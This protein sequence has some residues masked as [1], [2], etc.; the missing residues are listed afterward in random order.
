V[1]RDIFSSVVEK[2]VCLSRVGETGDGYARPS[3]AKRGVMVGEG[4]TLRQRTV[5]FPELQR[6][7]VFLYVTGKCCAN[8]KMSSPTGATIVADIVKKLVPLRHSQFDRAV[9]FFQRFLESAPTDF[10]LTPPSRYIVESAQKL[11]AAI[12]TGS[13]SGDFLSAVVVELQA[14]LAR[15]HFR[16]TR[17]P[18]YELVSESIAFPPI[19]ADNEVKA[20]RYAEV[21]AE[22]TF[23]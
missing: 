5:S 17:P 2:P 16:E 14:C 18:A 12:G 22:V 19:K 6:T 4:G 20:R 8:P 3:P 13:L 15:L 7:N 21:M 23:K 11:T 10:P 1:E 9:R